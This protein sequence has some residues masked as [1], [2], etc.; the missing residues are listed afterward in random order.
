MAD[1]SHAIIFL[2]VKIKPRGYLFLGSLGKLNYKFIIID[3]L[4]A[5]ILQ[6]KSL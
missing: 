3:L 2:M 6:E 1:S 5:K 4:A